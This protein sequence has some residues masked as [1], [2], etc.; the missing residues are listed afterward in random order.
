MKM[1]PQK[2]LLE[3]CATFKAE[4]KKSEKKKSD[5]YSFL[6]PW[7]DGGCLGELWTKQPI[8]M[9]PDKPVTP[10]LFLYWIAEQCHGIA[11]AL[12]SMHDLRQEALKKANLDSNQQVD[13]EYYGIHGD[14][15]PENI[16]HFSQLENLTGLGILKIADFG[17][18]E[19]HTLLSRTMAAQRNAP[20]PAPTYRAPEL[21]IPGEYFSRKADIWALGCVFSQFITW[22]VD[23]VEGVKEFDDF[24][25]EERDSDE[26]GE[27]KFLLDTFFKAHYVSDGRVETSLKRSTEEASILPVFL[28]KTR[29]SV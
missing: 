23:G 21:V 5:K 27:H 9:V 22:A 28:I 14:I 29:Y 15:K 8:N 10:R 17:L 7:A 16:L 2:H 24:R 12:H 1:R 11:T 3:L 6:F 13:D 19:F 20:V 25:K 18:T 4:N 26:K